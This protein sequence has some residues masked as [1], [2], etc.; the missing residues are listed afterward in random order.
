MKKFILLLL[1]ALCSFV[2]IGQN[3]YEIQMRQETT[4]SNWVQVNQSTNCQPSFYWV[5]TRSRTT[6]AYGRYLFKVYFQSNSRYC[7]GSWAGTYLQG[8]YFL[9]NGQTMNPN[10]P[11]WLMFKELYYNPI[12]SVWANDP[13]R[14]DM[15]IASIT[16][17]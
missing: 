1:L 7:D 15:N 10:N 5:V 8:V 2:A 16:V 17:N 11:Y 12:F 13:V 14:I 6:D 4:V 9:V 3:Q